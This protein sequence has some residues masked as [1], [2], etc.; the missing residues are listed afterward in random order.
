MAINITDFDKIWASTSPLTPYAFSDANY[1]EGWNFI[2]STPPARQMW[3]YMQNLNDLKM[4]WLFD[5]MFYKVGDSETYGVLVCAG[6]V[7]SGAKLMRFSF[8]T[9][10]N[11]SQIT[12]VQLTALTG[13]IRVPAGGYIDTDGTDLFSKYT[14]TA[15]KVTD[16]CIVVELASGSAISGATN[17]TNLS[18]WVRLTL[19]FS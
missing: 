3:D 6:E 7:T 4:Q 2:G 13:G 11:M 17:N 12:T 14:C 10:K 19:S 15:S 1:Q 9:P 5:S 8:F 18:F 16:N